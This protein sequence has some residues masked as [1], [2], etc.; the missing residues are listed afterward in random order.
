MAPIAQ[1]QGGPER[2]Q[3]KPG[4]D[5]EGG[6]ERAGC[7]ARELIVEAVLEGRGGGGGAAPAGPGG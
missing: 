5:E 3:R 2:Q 4:G 6:A 7:G 1:C